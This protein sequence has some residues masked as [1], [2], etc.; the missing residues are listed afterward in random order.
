[1]TDDPR[2]G[3]ASD[4]PDDRVLDDFDAGTAPASA[5]DAEAQAPYRRMVERLRALPMLE[6][7]AGW[8]ERSVARLRAVRAAER[9]RRALGA[10]AGLAGLSAAVMAVVL[11]RRPSPARGAL[12]VAV[13]SPDGLARR[14]PAALG[15]RL[16]ARVP[17][18][19]A[20][21]ELR[22]YRDDRLVARC[23]AAAAPPPAAVCARTGPHQD[24]ELRFDIHDAGTYRVVALASATPLPPP[25]VGGLDGDL[26]AARTAGATIV[27]AARLLVR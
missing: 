14:G 6:P 18:S 17:W 8:E 26:L 1:M 3:S 22:V 27:R 2:Q 11:L 23:P 10:A 5:A 15:D 13:A 7:P 25:G 16:Q 19:K 12:Q 9:R 21:V 4:P 24:L 20:E